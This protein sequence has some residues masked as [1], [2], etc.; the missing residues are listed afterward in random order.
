M[1]APSIPNLLSL[2]SGGGLQQRRGGGSQPLRS[3]REPDT[4]P[5]EQSKEQNDLIVQ[6]TDGDANMSRLSAV[7]AGYL[8][9]EFAAEFKP[10]GEVQRRYPIINRGA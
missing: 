4:P 3:V 7:A 8:D 9:D 10:P 2:R 6:A 5:P 1:A